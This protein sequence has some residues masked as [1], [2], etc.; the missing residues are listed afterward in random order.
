[1][2]ERIWIYDGERGEVLR[3]APLDPSVPR[4]WAAAIGAAGGLVGAVLL[5]GPLG[6]LARW[7]MLLALAVSLVAG[8]RAWATIIR[9]CKGDD[10]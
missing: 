1:M 7:L 8:V 5:W 9:T 2:A 4:R 3:A 10:R 6:G